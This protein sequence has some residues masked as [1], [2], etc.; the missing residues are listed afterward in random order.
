MKNES[1]I[2]KILKIIGIIFLI[3]I[4]VVVL[5]ALFVTDKDKWLSPGFLIAFFLVILAVG[6]PFRIIRWLR[7]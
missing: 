7:K 1:I 2:W 5:C 6:L 4:I 3:E